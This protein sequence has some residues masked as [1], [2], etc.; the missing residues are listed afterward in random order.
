MSLKLYVFDELNRFKDVLP[1]LSDVIDF[2]EWH[3]L[4]HDVTVWM[5]RHEKPIKI[6]TESMT[7][8]ILEKDEDYKTMKKVFARN[9]EYWKKYKSDDH[10]YN[11]ANAPKYPT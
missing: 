11:F 4:Y 9:Y 5:S 10:D 2:D 7:Y 8:Y 1:T 6:S 3:P